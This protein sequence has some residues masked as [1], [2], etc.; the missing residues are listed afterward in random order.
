MSIHQLIEFNNDDV[1]L[2][3][4]SLETKDAPDILEFSSFTLE[5]MIFKLDDSEVAEVQLIELI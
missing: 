4:D 2:D 1:E 5:E 3:K